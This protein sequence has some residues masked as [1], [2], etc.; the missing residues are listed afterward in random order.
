MTAIYVPMTTSCSLRKMQIFYIDVGALPPHEPVLFF[1]ARGNTKDVAV[2]ALMPYSSLVDVAVNTEETTLDSAA[3]EEALEETRDQLANQELQLR[4]NALTIGTLE[5]EI[6][7]LN[8]FQVLLAFVI[9]ERK[10]MCQ[11]SIVAT[12]RIYFLME[13]CFD[14]NLAAWHCRS[15]PHSDCHK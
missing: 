2:D 11:L 15:Q 12:H 1:V 7:S 4:E 6:A 8:N 3:L 10:C 13:N 5:N 9:V 14:G